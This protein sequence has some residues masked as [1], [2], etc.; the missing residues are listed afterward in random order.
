MLIAV[1]GVPAGC[2]WFGSAP[3][4]EESP[5][6]T[7]PPATHEDVL[8][9]YLQ[10]MSALGSN[11]PARQSDVF[12]E[13]EREYKK[14][15]TTAAALRYALALITPGHPGA[16]PSEGKKLLEF[17]L[18]NPDRLVPAE[19]TFADILLTQV[20][21]RLKSETETRRLLETL[22]LRNRSQANSDK[23]LLTQQTEEIARLKRALLDAEKK[24]DLIKDIE[25][26]LLERSSTSPGNRDTP[27][28]AQSP[29]T[30]R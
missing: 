20:V 3:I 10:T 26:S 17:L 30:G 23:R 22:D 25:R 12:Y 2:G 11:D 21:A 5:A 1:L 27:S 29:P 7:V 6:I 18:S 19:R 4:K 24:L 13:V 28:E 15:P 14:A 9:L 16:K 8:K